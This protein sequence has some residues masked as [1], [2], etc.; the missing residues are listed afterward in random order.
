MAQAWRA[1]SL[2][3]LVVITV[4]SLTPLPELPSAGGDKLLHLVAYACPAFVIALGASANWQWRVAMCVVWSGL[5]ELVQPY[6]NRL[7]EWED[8]AANALGCLLGALLGMVMAKFGA[9]KS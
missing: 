9:A 2:C 1:L 6:V 4:L 3:L 7:A 5:I 8:L